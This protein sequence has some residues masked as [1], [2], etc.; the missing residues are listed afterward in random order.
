MYHKFTTVFRTTVLHCDKE[1]C[2]CIS[3]CCVAVPALRPLT[4][5]NV[6]PNQLG[7]MFKKYLT[8]LL[9]T[10]DAADE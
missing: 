1:G 8:C 5:P 9:Y 4:W 2:I 10:S 6:Q 7:Q 3:I